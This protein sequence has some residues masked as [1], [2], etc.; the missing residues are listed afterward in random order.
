MAIIHK[1]LIASDERTRQP[2]G[3]PLLA[4]ATGPTIPSSPPMPAQPALGVVTVAAA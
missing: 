3:P 2:G 4:V 1:D